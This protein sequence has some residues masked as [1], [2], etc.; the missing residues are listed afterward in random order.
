MRKY[1]IHTTKCSKEHKSLSYILCDEADFRRNFSYNSIW[2]LKYGI[3]VPA[4]TFRQRLKTYIN[5]CI[6]DEE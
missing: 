1:Y 2:P 5:V 6:D 4:A 3:C